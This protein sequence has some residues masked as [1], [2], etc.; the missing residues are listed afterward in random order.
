MKRGCTL[1]GLSRGEESFFPHIRKMTTF[2]I[3]LKIMQTGTGMCTLFGFFLENS[4]SAK[5]KN[6]IEVSIADRLK[7]E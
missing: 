2:K 7:K 5:T 4:K 1:D 3:L 6:N